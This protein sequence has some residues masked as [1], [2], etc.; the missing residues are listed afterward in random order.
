MAPTKATIKYAKPGTQ[1][2]I[3]LAGS[4]SNPPWIP[5]PMQYTTD[6]HNEHEFFKE[7]AVEE[8]HDYQYKFRI[9]EGDWWMLNENSPVGKHIS[10]PLFKMSPFMYI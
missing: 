4:F 6:E 10:S 5:L 7:V 8:G 2:P 1:P 3:Y 9:G